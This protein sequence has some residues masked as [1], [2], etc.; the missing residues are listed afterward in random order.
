MSGFVQTKM[1]ESI[2]HIPVAMVGDVH[3]SG[4]TVVRVN[5]ELAMVKF[6]AA[7]TGAYMKVVELVTNDGANLVDAGGITLTG[8]TLMEQ[9]VTGSKTFRPVIQATDVT[10]AGTSN[11]TELY[12]IVDYVECVIAS[13]GVTS[14][15]NVHLYVR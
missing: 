11:A 1:N 5:G 8:D 7:T 3:G 9:V 4:D 10:G 13:G 14:G 2:R 6:Y 15:G 12:P